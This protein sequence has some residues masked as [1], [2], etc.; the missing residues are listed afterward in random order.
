LQE[1]SGISQL[2]V[3]IEI[4]ARC[5]MKHKYGVAKNIRNLLLTSLINLFKYDSPE[6]AELL[7]S[8][9]LDLKYTGSMARCRLD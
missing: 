7:Q 9:I 2:S 5:E 6:L 8:W 3:V 4:L 1:S